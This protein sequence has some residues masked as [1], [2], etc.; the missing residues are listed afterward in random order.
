MG[1]IVVK[2]LAGSRQELEAVDGWRIMEILREHG[3]PVEGL[4]GGACVCA[5]CHVE[6]APDWAD[7]LHTR[8]DDEEDMLDTVP[9]AG[10]LSRLSCQL[11]YGP[12][13]DGLEVVLVDA[14]LPL[15]DGAGI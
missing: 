4:C 3:M 2:D 13:M 1:I 8:R 10:P 15:I 7:R 14:E 6:V 11:I 5:T 9:N 12:E